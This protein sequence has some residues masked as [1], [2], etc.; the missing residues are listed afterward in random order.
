MGAFPARQ[1]WIDVARGG[2]ASAVAL[3]HIN[4]I[5]PRDGSIYSQLNQWGWLGVP[6]FF[7]FSGYCVFLASYKEPSVKNYLIRRLARIYPAYFASLAFIVGL[8]AIRKL[9][10]GVND[11]TPVPQTVPGWL[12]TLS[13][14]TQPVSHVPTMN[15]AYWTLSYE[16]AFYLV[17]AAA[18]LLPAARW[19]WL[20]GLTLL[21]TNQDLAQRI[22]FLSHWGEFA[23]GI[24]IAWWHLGGKREGGLLALFAVVA[25]CRQVLGPAENSIALLTGAGLLALVRLQFWLGQPWSWLSRAGEASY[26]L[27]LLHVPLGCWVV[28]R[29]LDPTG[30]RASGGWV[31]FGC[32]LI[33]LFICLIAS[34]ALFRWVELPGIKLGKK[35]ARN[36]G[37]S[38][39][40]PAS[41]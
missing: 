14:T 3:F 40:Q 18:I 1:P 26:S 19:W 28:C 7:V 38:S 10:T 25:I 23:L 2:A 22:F 32:D 33:V 6:V 39:S 16:V 30:W 36:T 24:A 13:I 12:A 27:Y 8:C 37:P 21:A 31:H 41:A 34:L 5:R 17:L 20:A 4:E 11:Y 29:L 15:W 35:L 9:A